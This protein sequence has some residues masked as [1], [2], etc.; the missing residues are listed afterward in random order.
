VTAGRKQPALRGKVN[1]GV[2]SLDVLFAMSLGV[3]QAAAGVG[4]KCRADGVNYD[5][6]Q[7]R[8]IRGQLSRCE[9]NQ[10][11]PTWKVLADTCPESALPFELSPLLAL[12]PQ[13]PLP[14]C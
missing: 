13:P 11:V 3:G 14:R 10:N 12:L 6:G 9:M 7:V 2:V 5:E 8:C 1:H 4:C